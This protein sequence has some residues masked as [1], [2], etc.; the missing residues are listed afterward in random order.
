MHEPKPESG[1]RL[2]YHERQLPVIQV[3]IRSEVRQFSIED[4]LA[5]SPAGFESERL[6]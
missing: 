5:T 6:S 4:G 3:K 1:G 2:A